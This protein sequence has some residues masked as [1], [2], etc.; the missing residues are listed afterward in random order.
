[1]A[2]TQVERFVVF[3]VEAIASQRGVSIP[4]GINWTLAKTD[5]GTF[6]DPFVAA[7]L[8]KE[9]EESHGRRR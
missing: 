1:M 9:E 7:F 6:L 2:D 3:L 5:I 4:D 8:K